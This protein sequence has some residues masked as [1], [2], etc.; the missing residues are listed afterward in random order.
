MEGV[1]ERL[2]AYKESLGE[3]FYLDK[4]EE[5]GATNGIG[6]L[7]Y[8]SYPAHLSV[9]TAALDDIEN[10]LAESARSFNEQQ[11]RSAIGSLN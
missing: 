6:E 8:F 5:K 1:K 7:Q 11:R 4:P 10:Q 9:V 3:K 2:Q